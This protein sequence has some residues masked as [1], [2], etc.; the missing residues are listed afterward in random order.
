MD[1]DN[2]SHL[3]AKLAALLEPSFMLP[4]IDEMV[5]D[6]LDP[7]PNPYI[8]RPVEWCSE[9]LQED[10]WSKQREIAE[11]VRDNRYTAVQSCHGTGKSYMASR[12]VSWWLSTHPVGSAFAV[13]TAPTQRQIEAI[14][15]RYIRA[16]HRKGNLEG[17]TTL[18]SQWFMGTDELV[19][20]GSK[21]KDYTNTDEA[22]QAFQGIHARYVLVVMDEACGIPKWLWNAVDTLVTNSDSRVLAIGNPDDPSSQFEKVC[23]PGSGWN[24]IKIS[25]KDSPNFTGEKVSE[26]IAAEL[27][28]PDWVE[29]RRQRWGD[30]SNLFVAKCK[31]E[32]P[33]TSDDTLISSDQ[34]RR[35]CENEL[36]ST[37]PTSFGLDVARTGSDETACYSVRNGVVRMELRLPDVSDTME[38]VGKA[39][40]LFRDL[41]NKVTSMKVDVIGVGGGVYDRMRE[42]GHPVHA[43]NSSEKARN[44]R[45]F[46]NRRAEAYWAVRSMLENDL[47]DLDGEDEELISQLGSIKWKIDSAGRIQI[48]SKEEMAKRGISSPDLADAVVMALEPSPMR[49]FKEGKVKAKTLTGDLLNMP[50]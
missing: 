15:W 11:S 31:G 30:K 48:E 39:G 32:F 37:G 17:R 6:M 22:M 13:T 2:R 26:E 47:L 33:P 49:D 29:E 18:N 19:A 40:E 45:K 7:Q 41:D 34:L 3:D 42:L 27:I 9:V 43:F 12:L 8:D 21:P 1:N 5:A 38:I 24:G 25:Y 4:G 14:L 50:M 20:Y 16:T 46:K 23:K 36:L 10:L 44:P 35:A 28:S